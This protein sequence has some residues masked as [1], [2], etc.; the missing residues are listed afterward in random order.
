M[1]EEL[2]AVTVDTY[3]LQGEN[4]LLFP[5]QKSIDN[6]K[7]HIKTLKQIKIF[8]N[9]GHGIETYAKAMNY[10]GLKIKNYN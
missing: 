4:D 9:V 6:A 2:V 7:I 3:L 10:I 8:E 5:Y 1:N